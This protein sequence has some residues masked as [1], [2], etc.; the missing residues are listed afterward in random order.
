MGAAMAVRPCAFKPGVFYENV[1]RRQ[2]E[3]GEAGSEYL[4]H[5]LCFLRVQYILMLPCFGCFLVVRY[6]FHMST[7]LGTGGCQLIV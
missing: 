2:V 1:V 7:V 5:V 4:C 3:R 6:N